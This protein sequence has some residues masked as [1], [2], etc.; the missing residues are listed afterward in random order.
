MA[1]I[2]V[3]F[4]VE[5]NL[6]PKI[7]AAKQKLAELGQA[8]QAAQAQA[9]TGGG[10]FG[11]GWAANQGQWGSSAA[12][13][14]LKEIRETADNAAWSLKETESELLRMA[15]AEDKA[16]QKAKELAAA[17]AEAAKVEQVMAEFQYRN[18]A[19][20]Q[21]VADREA[22]GEGAKGGLEKVKDLMGE[23]AS[24]ISYNIGLWNLGMMASQFVID[25]AVEGYQMMAD[26]IKTV[27]QAHNQLNVGLG[28]GVQHWMAL[29]SAANDTFQTYEATAARFQELTKA[30]FST[31]DAE[32]EVRGLQG[33]LRDT[34]VDLTNLDVASRRFKSTSAESI[35]PTARQMQGQPEFAQLVK[36]L[37]PVQARED[38][39]PLTQMQM[40]EQIRQEELAFQVRSKWRSREMED[41]E[42]DIQREMEM[43]DLAT[44]REMEHRHI[45]EER[46]MEERF[47]AINREM[48]LRHLA[49]NQE[50]QD[51]HRAVEQAVAD[52]DRMHE[53]QRGLVGGIKGMTQGAF[54]AFTTRERVNAP[55]QE[56]Q[57]LQDEL[58]KTMEKGAGQ[59]EKDLGLSSGM[60][61]RIA[62][63]GLISP[64]T[65]IQEAE[66]QRQEQRITE[67][68]QRQLEAITT[69]RQ[70]QKEAFN[71]RIAQEDEAYLRA[72]AYQDEEIATREAM[73]NKHRQIEWTMQNEQR[74][75]Q[76]AVED[77]QFNLQYDH[78]KKLRDYEQESILEGFRTSIAAAAALARYKERIGL[79]PAGSAPKE[80]TEGQA[81]EDLKRVAAKLGES[82]EAKTL[83][84]STDNLT[85]SQDALNKKM[86]EVRSAYDDLIKKIREGNPSQAPTFSWYQTPGTSGAY[87][88]VGTSAPASGWHEQAVTTS[89]P[90][91][92]SYPMAERES[93]YPGF[94]GG[95]SPYGHGQRRFNK[96]T[97]KWEINPI[98]MYE[99]EAQGARLPTAKEGEAQSFDF[100]GTFQKLG[101]SE[102]KGQ[103]TLPATER[104]LLAIG[105][106]LKQVLTT[107]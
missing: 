49:I 12:Q 89:T 9:S 82:P 28:E 23:F 64:E 1:Q 20:M 22:K 16:A 103:Y 85:D 51:R 44:N 105:E 102:E 93:I 76:R 31:Q 59:L 66:V 17:Q 3:S 48:E 92:A 97:N 98:G 74:D 34:G 6:T 55:M 83:D 63:A 80:G 27:W 99:R 106:T 56:L 101:K 37:E 95:D 24:G 35:L 25:K 100:A 78:A 33:V 91:G 77:A 36:Q 71:E 4:D 104:T 107:G 90:E 57:G 30:G 67:E 41:R 13:N 14:S 8:A 81:L 47:R 72:K 86:G 52:Q 65:L 94:T 19:R 84:Q 58:A 21:H 26:A 42:R 75:L 54:T 43:E 70:L 88:G 53:R 10:L 18:E 79:A 45:A 40:Q 2:I 7:E 5:D 38:L 87:Q 96:A 46:E 29:Q 60:G 39:R 73:E 11:S 61:R 50:M 15:Q 69:G 68:R 62:Q 32:K